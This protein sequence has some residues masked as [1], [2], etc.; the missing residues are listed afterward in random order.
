MTDAVVAVAVV[1]AGFAVSIAIGFTTQEVATVFPHAVS[2]A[3]I[4]VVADNH[5]VSYTD[6]FVAVPVQNVVASVASRAVNEV[7]KRLLT[8]FA[9]TE[10][11]SAYGESLLLVDAFDLVGTGFCSLPVHLAVIVRTRISVVAVCVP[12]AGR[13][14]GVP[15]KGLSLKAPIFFACCNFS[16]FLSLLNERVSDK[17]PEEPSHHKDYECV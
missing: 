3:G 8:G 16:L 15:E 14:G 7:S 10:G 12:F 6:T 13:D 2:R 1:V 11:D 4:V 5:R 17:D 9:I